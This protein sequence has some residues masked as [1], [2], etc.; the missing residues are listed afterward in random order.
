MIPHRLYRTVPETTT[1]EVEAFWAKA[2]ELH[3][4]WEHITYREQVDPAWFP[5]TG[6]AFERCDSG[7]QKAGLIRLELLLHGGGIYIDSDVELY[8]P[9]DSLCG[10]QGFAAWEDA[11]VVPDAVLGAKADHPAIGKCLQLALERIT[12]GSSDWRTGSGA[13]STGPGVTTTVLPG[14]SDFAL[15]PPGSFYPYHYNEKGRRH[16][17]HAAAQPWAFGAHHWHHSWAQVPA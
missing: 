15:L 10:L 3:P 14:R 12:S 16:E 6:R 11:D 13:W 1:D 5:I 9:L 7:A 17:D 8:R 4:T 2:C